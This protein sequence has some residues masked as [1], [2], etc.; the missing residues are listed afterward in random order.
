VRGRS[1][2]TLEAHVN[3]L[4]EVKAGTRV[5]VDSRVLAHDTKRIHVYFEMFIDGVE[6]P[7]SASEQMWLHV[8]I[9][10]PRSAPFDPDVLARLDE[11]AA[12]HAAL[13]PARHAGRTISLPAAARIA[14]PIR[15]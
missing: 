1:V 9:S 15:R 6:D 7:V 8:D 10:G 5:R 12:A 11:I 4:R 14:P 2:F 13:P 3:Y